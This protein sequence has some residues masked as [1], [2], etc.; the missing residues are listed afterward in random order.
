[1]SAIDYRLAARRA[2]VR[3]SL[4]RSRLRWLVGL[5][6]VLL[7]TGA[8][9]VAL[10]SPILAVK[11]VE[12]NGVVNANVDA[13]L[14]AHGIEMGAPTV[15]VRPGIVE[16]AVMRDPWVAKADVRV[17]WPGSVEVTVLEHDPAGWIESERG[18]VRASATGAILERSDP[19]VHAP[20]VQGHVVTGR[21]GSVIEDPAAVA[22]LEFLAYLP[23]NVARDAHIAVTKKGVLRAVVA[24]HVVRLG[25]P[26]DIASKAASLLAVLGSKLEEGARISVVAPTRPAVTGAVSTDEANEDPGRGNGKT[27]RQP[28]I[29]G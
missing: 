14:A 11:S 15:A 26:E 12:V 20:T 6:V 24:G 4:A 21:P 18:W 13:I 28:S 25:L 8:V 3:E 9:L 19:P 10:R 22:A 17:V 23:G 27:D 1:L 29:D 5:V 2:A 16:A 7:L